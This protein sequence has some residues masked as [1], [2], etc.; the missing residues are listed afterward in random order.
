M[1][2]KKNQK[3]TLDE[4][5]NSSETFFIKNRKAILGGVGV[6]VVLI[7]AAI[8]Y[9]SYVSLP[10]ED[11]AS[12]E[13]SKSEQLMMQQQYE[14]ALKGFQKVAEDYSGTDAGNLANLYTGLCY[15]H[16]AK[17]NWAKA[18]E[19]VEKFDTKSDAIISPESQVALGDIYANN[20]ELD[21]AVASFKKAADMA[22]SKA[23]DGV[24]LSVAPIALLKAG[25]ILENQGKKAEALEIYQNIK[26]TYVASPIYQEVDKYIERASR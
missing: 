10:R 14:A 6:V 21:K 22:N 11:E 17:P 24:N 3:G 7:I 20:N 13:L 16:Q 8:L 2:S 15:A 4:S 18:K 26:K 12:T 25:Q 9:H 5:L 23:T 1:S 19:A